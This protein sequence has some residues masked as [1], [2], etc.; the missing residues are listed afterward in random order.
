MR[1]FLVS[2]LAFG[3]TYAFTGN[4]TVYS[5]IQYSRCGIEHNGSVWFG[6][7]GG[8]V[9]LDPSKGNY[10]VYTHLDGL[11]D[12]DIVSL[13][14]DDDGNLWYAAANGYIGVFSDGKWFSAGELADNHY[15]INRMIFHDGG[16]WI[17]TSSGLVRANP[18]P[19]TFTIA[20]FVDFFEHFA[21]LPVQTEATDIAFLHDTVFVGTPYCLAF[22]PM[23]TNL[24]AS[25]S[26]DTVAIWL[27]ETQSRGITA[28]AVHHDTLWALAD[29]NYGETTLFFLQNGTFHQAA[30]SYHDELAYDLVS[31]FDTLW[32]LSFRGIFYYSSATNTM[33]K[34][35]VDG[36][37]YSV[38]SLVDFCGEKIVGTRYGYATFDG[39]TFRNVMFNAP[40]GSD[41]ADV[42]FANNG[43]VVVAA[44]N[45]GANVFYDGKWSQFNIHTTMDYV[46]DD[47]LFDCVSRVFWAVCSAVLTDDGTIWIGSYGNGLL[48]ITENYSF[49]VWNAENSSLVSSVP[50]ENYT[51]VSKLR[52]D[53]MGNL[54]IASFSSTD[55]K[56]L[57]IWTPDNFGN[58]YG[59][60]SFGIDEGI[61][62]PTIM[63]M[64]CDYEK[65]A[66]ATASGAAVIYHNGTIADKSDDVYYNLSGLLPSNEV[67]AVAIGADG[68]IWFGTADGLA[69]MDQSGIIDTLIMP[70]DIS[71]TITSLAADSFGNI[72]IGTLDGAAMYMPDGYFATFK[73]AFSDDALEQDITPLYSDAVGVISPI[74]LGGVFT[75]GRSGDI[76]FGFNGCAVVLHSPYSASESLK[77]LKIY[78]NPAVVERRIV[79]TIYIADVPPD[80]PLLIYNSAGELVRQI[81]HYWKAQD[82]VFRWDCTNDAGQ[83]VAPGVY[84][85]AAPSENGI[86]KGKLLLIR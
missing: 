50:G 60:I 45:E 65:I 80:A 52:V 12:L 9:Q 10:A 72:W 67:Y 38:Y 11:G 5:D 4:W 62:A 68:K 6:T 23:D 21:D 35:P 51:V 26:W 58:P 83:L 81:E 30:P 61:P 66:V 8:I 74:P 71:G 70:T 82:G 44:H 85:I 20:Q 63:S 3:M 31:M 77:P 56:P 73:S 36:P 28:L 39:D 53:P 57:K 79:P 18:A 54:C 48:K 25:A 84:V 40:V 7:E 34:I 15:R 75:D 14:E 13:T 55:Q 43:A 22:A 19:A 69:Y 42:A 49:D 1:L 64:D 47:S 24:F 29:V 2:I 59:G 33:K 41:V 32:S 37:F 78:P 16:L 86:A 17:C 76:W 46:E 27:D